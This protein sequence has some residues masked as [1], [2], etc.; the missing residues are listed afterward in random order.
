MSTEKKNSNTPRHSARIAAVQA[1][2]QIEQSGDTPKKVVLDMID[3][4]F[5]SLTHEGYFLP[6]DVFFEALVHGTKDNE[7][8]LNTIISEFLAEN[9]RIERIASVLRHILRLATFEL[10][11]Y[12]NIHESIIINEYI[13]ITKDFFD[14]KG[15]VGFVNG[16]LDNVT[17][18]L[19]Q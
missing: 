12:P 18:K 4:N 17:K 2:Y 7:E 11:F 8:E 5:N 13:E 1:L 14:R 19:R 9:W 10:R 6:D 3:A 15:E 16:V